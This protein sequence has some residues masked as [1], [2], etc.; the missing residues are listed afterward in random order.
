MQVVLPLVSELHSEFMRERHWKQLMNIAGQTFTI[1]LFIFFCS[2]F[3]YLCSIE[4][5]SLLFFICCRCCTAQSCAQRSYRSSLSLFSSIFL[6]VL[7]VF[8]LLDLLLFVDWLVGFLLFVFRLF[9]PVFFLFA[10]LRLSVSLCV[11]VRFCLLFCLAVTMR[12]FVSLSAW[13]V[14]CLFA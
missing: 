4:L 14:Y 8:L 3:P 2:S 11:F 10:G 1:G 9:V 12:L 13:F 5:S 7:L 6:F